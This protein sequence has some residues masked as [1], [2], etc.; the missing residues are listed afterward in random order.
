MYEAPWICDNA[1]DSL[2]PVEGS[3]GVAVLGPSFSATLPPGCRSA[4]RKRVDGSSSP[5][6][7]NRILREGIL[8]S[9]RIN[10]LSVHAELFYRRLL[11]VVDDYGRFFAHPA[12]LRSACYPLRVDPA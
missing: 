2:T 10:T 5:P 9:E 1:D 12:L 8:S 7:P 3:T 11:S 4:P 6:M